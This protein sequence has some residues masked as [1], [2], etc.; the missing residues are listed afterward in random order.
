[1]RLQVDGARVRAFV[2]GTQLADVN[3]PSPG[4]LRGAKVEFGVGSLKN[5][6]QPTHRH[7]RQVE[8]L[9]PHAVA[10]GRLATETIERPRTFRP[11]LRPRR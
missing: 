4:E 1:M 2:N 10:T 8:A 6:K 7:V 9:D 11:R 5:T 3:D